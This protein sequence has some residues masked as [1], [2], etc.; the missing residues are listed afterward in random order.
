MK[1]FQSI[2]ARQTDK[3]QHKLLNSPSRAWLQPNTQQHTTSV[4]RISPGAVP[5][6]SSGGYSAK[7]KSET[8]AEPKGFD[9][10][11]LQAQGSVSGRGR[12]SLCLHAAAHAA[13][14]ACCTHWADAFPFRKKEKK[15]RDIF[16]PCWLHIEVAISPPHVQSLL[17]A[18]PP[19]KPAFQLA[20]HV[21]FV[22]KKGAHLPATQLWWRGGWNKPSISSTAS[23]HFQ[24]YSRTQLQPQGT[25]P[26]SHSR[27]FPLSSH[28]QRSQG[29][30]DS[31]DKAPEMSTLVHTLHSSPRDPT[32]LFLLANTGEVCFLDASHLTDT[33]VW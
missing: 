29:T 23:R 6:G 15:K 8:A 19:T 17:L 30:S 13:C 18:G 10:E 28:P 20:F 9:P 5:S 2:P 21:S 22:F 11:V 32:S 16:I 25:C 33:P 7:R 27:Q 3:E 4:R 14:Q 1:W 24:A 12:T 26:R 31:S